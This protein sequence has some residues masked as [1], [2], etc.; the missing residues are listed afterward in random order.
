MKTHLI[1][2]LARPLKKIALVSALAGIMLGTTLSGVAQAD[3]AIDG[4]AAIVNDDVVLKSE[5][6]QRVQLVKQRFQNRQLPPEDQLRHQVLEQLALERLQLSLAKNQGIRVSDD[7]L[8]QTLQ[9]TAQ[10]NNMDLIQFKKALEAE[11]TSFDAFRDEI[12]NTMII[13]RLQQ[14]VVNSRIQISEADI[15]QLMKNPNSAFGSLRFHLHHILIPLPENPTADQIDAAKKKADEVYK[16]AKAGTD[17]DQLALTYSG[18]Q[19]ALEGGDMGWKSTAELPSI[20]SG[21]VP[22]MGV[23]DVS[24]PI[25]SAS[26]FHIVKLVERQGAPNTVVQQT[27]VRHILLKPTAI[28]N[29]AQTEAL[30]KQLRQRLANGED[31]AKLAKEYTDDI[32]SKVGGGDLN[33]VNP[34]QTVP[35]FENAMNSLSPG[36]ISQPVQSQFGW[37]II[38]VLERR[39]TDMSKNM[40]ANEARNILRQ[41]RYQEELQNWLREVKSEAYI[42]YKY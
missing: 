18:S 3:T 40:L 21:V 6:D 38:Q 36:E 2:A 32:G 33:W 22:T 15:K 42:D 17:F 23:G 28:R 20:F 8:Y 24:E 25:R 14:Q 1:N 37:H 5:L 7:E 26:G 39:K 13:Q 16:E 11:G 41:Q 34:G 30:A 35:A 12:R 19:T 29:E 27:H 31:F 4:V 10:R 9:R